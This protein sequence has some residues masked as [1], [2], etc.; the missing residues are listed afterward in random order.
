M[1]ARHEGRVVF[2][3]GAV[4]GERV[5]ARIERRRQ[6]VLWA[7]VTDVLEASPDRRAPGA[8]PACGGMAYAHIAYARQL[9]L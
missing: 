8:D 6:Q 1:L 7:T 5:R 3:A 2:V 9:R 4:P